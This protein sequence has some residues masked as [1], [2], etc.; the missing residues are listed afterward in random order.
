MYNYTFTVHLIKQL[1]VITAVGT[2]GK[3]IVN[4]NFYIVRSCMLGMVRY[5][6]YA[7]VHM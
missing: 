6:T 4:H 5:G 3:G 2:V 7:Y 1:T